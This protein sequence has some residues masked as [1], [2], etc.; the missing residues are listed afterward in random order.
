MNMFAEERNTAPNAVVGLGV[1]ARS[2][3]ILRTYLHLLGAII[4]FVLAEIF[5]FSTGIAESV[6]AFAFNSSWLLILG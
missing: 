4:L 1:E 3:F 5:F 6:I 2:Q